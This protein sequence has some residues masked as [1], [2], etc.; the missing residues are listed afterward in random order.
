MSS[1]SWTSGAGSGDAPARRQ[2]DFCALTCACV[3]RESPRIQRMLTR[4]ILDDKLY[5]RAQ[6]TMLLFLPLILTSEYLLKVLF[7]WLVF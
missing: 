2:Q 4:A 3:E 7:H 1:L 5:E 6:P